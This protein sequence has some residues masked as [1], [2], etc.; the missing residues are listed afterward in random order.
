M[1]TENELKP[2]PFCGNQAEI[3]R[4][5]VSRSKEYAIGCSNY[6]CEANNCEQDE[7]GGF[8]SY[9]MKLEDAI[10]SWNTRPIEDNLRAQLAEA[11]ADIK[12]LK[13]RD[14]WLVNHIKEADESA[15]VAWGEDLEDDDEQDSGSYDSL[16]PDEYKSSWING[17]AQAIKHIKENR[18]IADRLCP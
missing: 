7:Q 17:A 11:Q 2:C 1:S 9:F 6:E 5:W 8:N 15:A 16:I 12:V 13:E 18:A 10:A 4:S 14:A 3:K